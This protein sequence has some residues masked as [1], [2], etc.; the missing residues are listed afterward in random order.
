[1]VKIWSRF[2]TGNAINYHES[3]RFERMFVMKKLTKKSEEESPVSKL[4]TKE[5][6]DMLAAL[7]INYDTEIDLRRR[8]YGY[9]DAAEQKDSPISKFLR[10]FRSYR[11]G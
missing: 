9:T 7:Y 1:M 4:L 10:D 8:K 3:G 11:V 2:V 6:T 5:E